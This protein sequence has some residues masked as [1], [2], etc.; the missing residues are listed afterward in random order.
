MEN[1]SK[2]NSLPYWDNRFSTDWETFHGPSQSRFFSDIAIKNMPR[3]L[4]DQLQQESLTLADW[5]CAQGDGT[6]VWAS[7]INHR[8]IV[9]VDFSSVAIV[10]ATNRYPAIR[11]I[12]DDWLATAPLNPDDYFDIVFSSNTLEHFHTPYDALNA[13]CQRARKAVFLVLPY[14]EKSRHPEHFFTF[15]PEN[16]PA[17]LANGF[18]LI[19][20]RV[21]DCQKLDNPLWNQEQIILIY[22]TPEWLSRL[23]LSLRDLY[24]GQDDATIS[25]D[26]L[27]RISSEYSEKSLNL[28][29]QVLDHEHRLSE[30]LQVLSDRDQRIKS[31]LQEADQQVTQ[32]SLL[33]QESSV[34]N[35]QIEHLEQEILSLNQQL[36]KYSQDTRRLSQATSQYCI[37]ITSL[38]Q[39]I[40]E[41]DHEIQRLAGEASSRS[42]ET[43]ALSQQILERDRETQRLSR[44]A[45]SHSLE[46]SALNQ[47]ILERDH[48][49]QRLSSEVARYAL[50]AS[51][52]NKQLTELENAMKNSFQE[53]T[54]RDEEIE[55][56]QK[57]NRA[58]EEQIFNHA[59][60]FK[61]I[62]DYASRLL[63]E[64]ADRDRQIQICHENIAL[65][66]NAHLRLSR[67]LA[68]ESNRVEKTQKQLLTM[69]DWATSIDTHP[70]HHAVKKT[71][72]SIARKTLRSLPLSVA[73]KQRLRQNFFLLVHF[74]M[75]KNSTSLTPPAQTILPHAPANKNKRDVFIFA[76]IDWHFRIQRPQHMARSLA[77]AG[78]RV[79]YFSNHFV[80]AAEPGYDIEVIPEADSLY[81]IKL[82]VQGAPAIYFDAPSP[83]AISMLTKSMALLVKDFRALSSLSVIQHAY[84]LPLVQKI[85]NSFRIYDCMDHHEGFGNVPEKLIE[86]EVKTLSRADLVTVTS[87]WL[88]GFAKKYNPNVSIIRNASEYAFFSTPP[89]DIYRDDENR[90]IIG[91]YGAIAEWFDLNLVRAIATEYPSHLILLVGN[92]TIEAQKA[93][94]DLK[95]IKFTGEVPYT[96]LPYYLYA[97]DVCLLPFQTISLTLATNPVKVYEYLAAGKPAVCTDLPEIRQFGNLVECA[98][99]NAQFIHAIGKILDSSVHADADLAAQRRQFAAEQTWQHRAQELITAIESVKLPRVSVI[100]LTYNN[101]DLTR[102]CLD[103]LIERSNYSNLEIIIVDNASSDATP[104]YLESFPAQ[105]P[106]MDI[107]IIL[108][109]KNLGFAAGNNVGLSKATGDFLVILNNDTVVTDG[110]VLT[111]LRHIQNNPGLG[112]V[113]PVTNNIGN[114]A[115]IP[116]H[117]ADITLMPAAALNYTLSH[118]GALYPLKNAAFFCV[119]MP[120]SVYESCGPISEDYGRGFFE[121]DD[122]CRKVDAAGLSI[123]C[124]EDVFVHHHLSAS[125][126]KLK[127]EERQ[128]LFNENKAIYEKK[129]GKWMPH[130]YRP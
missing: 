64:L 13:L 8:Q 43:S 84:W 30:L 61:T 119:M 123:A 4:L 37:E 89:N 9:G 102:A 44:E 116:I 14:R 76:V 25:A 6:D 33:T 69:S 23:G 92:D 68:I 59:Q 115:R 32:L 124:A 120:R 104:A 29:Q 111:L 110:W 54:N 19:W 106:Y 96:Q 122:Y 49:I 87:S 40:L 81:Q 105:H 34:R 103:S 128:K 38:T 56:L 35:L 45:S 101:L 127:D 77:E 24:I 39:Q 60:Q 126:N 15:L 88:D 12:Q 71:F 90:K 53:A 58:K 93:L 16:I 65:Q 62:E 125:F 41:R 67:L 117:Y 18:K 100:V 86:L 31:L 22:A 130:T 82:H 107:Q 36:S 72:L 5:G 94:A 91:Y 20:A 83:A 21:V 98:S 85:P 46:T 121:D 112:L 73:L 42:L 1:D 27:S 95:N 66:S 52:L 97:F 28:S 80:D 99:S 2:L 79:F 7:Y 63:K 118:M 75:K 74:F 113:G 108:N 78:H 57:D 11:F 109:N 55:V 3:W 17:A 48:E 26:T 51:L 50:D 47:Q 10:Q 114:E 70:I 129:W